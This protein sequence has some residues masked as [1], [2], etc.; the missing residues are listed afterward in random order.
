MNLL[1]YI[2]DN[3]EDLDNYNKVYVKP[4]IPRGCAV[5]AISEYCDGDT[6][7]DDIVIMIDNTVFG[8]CSLGMVITENKL[9]YKEMFRDRGTNHF[10]SINEIQLKKGLINCKVMINSKHIIELS[11][12]PR[13][14]MTKL[15]SLLSNYLTDHFDAEEAQKTADITKAE[16]AQ[17]VAEFKKAITA[18]EVEEARKAEET[19]MNRPLTKK[20]FD[21]ENEFKR[22]SDPVSRILFHM[23]G[24]ICKLKNEYPE[25]ND[26]KISL[27]LHYFISFYLLMF[28]KRVTQGSQIVAI[29]PE[30]TQLSLLPLV[31]M[32][33]DVFNSDFDSV[34]SELLSF[35]MFINS[36]T[37]QQGKLDEYIEDTFYS[38]WEELIEDLSFTDYVDTLTTLKKATDE[39]IF[40]MFKDDIENKKKLNSLLD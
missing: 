24:A 22:E 8:D 39:Y 5:G 6:H 15:F 31:I 40:N 35:T 23:I 21:L 14:A 29:S 9:F 17:R 30:A 36:T 25:I 32:A 34:Y 20:I 38:Q 2:T 19:R 37:L 7:Y 4:N 11:Q 12:P 28:Q 16:R 1:K 33:D 18:R 13:N 10:S 26:E 27:L 3:F